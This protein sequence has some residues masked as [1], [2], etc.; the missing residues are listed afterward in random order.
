MNALDELLQRAEAIAAK[1]DAPVDTRKLIADAVVGHFRE[2]EE[3]EFRRCA[4]MAHSIAA[5]V[6]S[7]PPTPNGMEMQLR[8]TAFRL[9]WR[10]GPV[11]LPLVRDTWSPWCEIVKG[12]ADAAP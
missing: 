11:A 5:E 2:L 3:I 8:G 7:F 6:R 10:G 12:D 4:P 1:V 9:R